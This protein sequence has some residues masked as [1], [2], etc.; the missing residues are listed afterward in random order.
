MPRHGSR[1]PVFGTN[2]WSIGIPGGGRPVGA[3]AAGHKGSGLAMASALLGALGMIDDPAPTAVGAA[4]DAAVRETRGRL[5]GVFV[6]AVD[7]GCLGDAAAS[8][9]PVEAHV[10]AARR[11]PPEAGGTEVLVPGEPA[12]RARERR[13]REGIPLAAATWAELGQAAARFGVPLP[14]TPRGG[15]TG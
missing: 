8:R 9:A 13:G 4:P 15:P 5:A 3:P 14:G 7:P 6:Q 11:M 10:A 1:S 12:A 2:P